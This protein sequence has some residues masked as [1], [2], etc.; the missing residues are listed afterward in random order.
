MR[1]RFICIEWLDATY[2]AGYYEDTDDEVKK[3][4]RLMPCQTIGHLIK[5]DRV[6]VIVAMD[7]FG[8]GDMRHLSIIPKKGIT[9]IRYLGDK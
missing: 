6:K 3:R 7:K 4:F 9:K 1:E 5:S 8:D 2:N